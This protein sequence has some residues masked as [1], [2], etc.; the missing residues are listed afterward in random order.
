MKSRA[1]MV[2]YHALATLYKL[3]QFDPLAVSK[4][5]ESNINSFRSPL[6]HCLL[7]KYGMRVLNDEGTL[8]R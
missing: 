8:T 5:V 7:I 6:A 4:L 2:Q 1:Y 3:R